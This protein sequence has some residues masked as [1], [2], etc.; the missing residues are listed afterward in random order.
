MAA[1]LLLLPCYP[2]SCIEKVG[3]KSRGQR[4]SS[5]RNPP[6]PFKNEFSGV[7]RQI[8]ERDGNQASV[9]KFF[10]AEEL[11]AL[12]AA[13]VPSPITGGYAAVSAGAS[14]SSIRPWKAFRLNLI[15]A[16]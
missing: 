10:A 12:S 3:G 2:K 11:C 6:L 16:F 1:H 9:L 15:R 7:P 4:R 8:L 5:A 13:L 14:S